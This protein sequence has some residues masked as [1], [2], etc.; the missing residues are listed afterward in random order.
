MFQSRWLVTLDHWLM[1]LPSPNSHMDFTA[2]LCVFNFSIMQPTSDE[3]MCFNA[4]CVK[5]NWSYWILTFLVDLWISR[6]LWLLDF[7]SLFLNVTWH[8]VY[9]VDGN[10]TPS[11]NL[12][13]D[14][15]TM[16]K[17]PFT[18]I[19]SHSLIYH[20]TILSLLFFNVFNILV[21]VRCQLIFDNIHCWQSFGLYFGWW[22]SLSMISIWSVIVPINSLF[23][24]SSTTLKS[25][26]R[27][28]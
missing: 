2:W 16:F 5:L 4:S 18:G 15:V 27:L 7:L 14:W 1:N 3:R 17:V 8:W 12:R 21:T 26:R 23:C 24:L 22:G 6:I 28:R 13:L 9:L 25:K 10:I 11:P 20:E 19:S